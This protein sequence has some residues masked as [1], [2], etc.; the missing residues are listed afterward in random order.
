MPM[1]KRSIASLAAILGLM[2]LAGCQS[3]PT[4]AAATV[5]PQLPPLPERATSVCQRPVAARDDDLGVLAAEWKATAVCEGGKR[6]SIIV[7]YRDLRAG[8][9]GQ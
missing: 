8:F 9:A 6:A 7:F 3:R 5:R 4:G 1:S 2:A